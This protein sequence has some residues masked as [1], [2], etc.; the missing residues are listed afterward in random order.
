MI[1]VAKLK[2]GESGIIK[3]VNIV[4]DALI[5]INEMGLT[6]GAK[7]TVKK[8]APLGD[9]LEITTRGYSLCLRT[10]DADKIFVEKE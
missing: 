1:T 9:P 5:R 4:G 6:E 3:K 8:K 10:G 2:I 7:V